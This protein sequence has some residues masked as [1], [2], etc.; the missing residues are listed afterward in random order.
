MSV[1]IPEELRGHCRGL[2][3]AIENLDA[4]DRHV[5]G[6]LFH[7]KGL[8]ALRED[9]TGRMAAFWGS[10]AWLIWSSRDHM[11]REETA[12]LN[13]M[14]APCIPSPRLEAWAWSRWTTSAV[15]LRY[16]F[17]LNAR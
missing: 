5:L 10:I 3:T 17:L 2:I 1:D 8:R 12:L 16:F 15:P 4:S 14:L 6:L 11:K 9:E 7:D 13:Q